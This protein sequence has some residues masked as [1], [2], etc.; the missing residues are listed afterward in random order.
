M[1]RMHVGSFALYT[2][3]MAA[4]AAGCSGAAT[5]G[6]DDAFAPAEASAASPAELARMRAFIESRYPR[7]AV[8]HEFELAS[9][10][11]VDCVDRLEQPSVRGNARALVSIPMAPTHAPIEA[12]GPGKAARGGSEP[13]LS[14]VFMLKGDAD[15]AGRARA[16]PEGSVPMVRL[17][18]DEMSRYPTL[19]AYLH[20]RAA[21]PQAR[22]IG[23]ERH[24]HAQSQLSV[25]NRGSESI[26]NLWNPYVEPDDGFSLSQTWVVRG[27]GADTET[28]ETGLQKWS[29][30][31]DASGQPSFFIYFTP[32]NYGAGGCYNLECS[33][34][35]QTSSS[36][37]IGQH[38]ATTSVSSGAQ[39]EI[40]LMFYKDGENGH[41]WLAYNGN[42]VGYY[43]RDLFDSN[44]LREHGDYLAFGG[45]VAVYPS[46][47]ATHT[48]TDMGSGAF[49]SAGYTRAAYQR[50]MRYIDTS[51][52]Y[53]DPSTIASFASAPGCY[54]VTLGNSP[55]VWGR[56]IFFGGPGQ[57]PT[58]P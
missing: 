12:G 22:T 35:V 17:S 33:G 7:A 1:K 34:F 48:P 8:V 57:S 30:R 51:S 21:L 44:G 54:S 18:L 37:V 45:E 56:Y 41:W 24:E 27:S 13:P 5:G 28:V 46:G 10:Q 23:A 26:L 9:G 3:L 32:D 42:W 58:C 49:A 11:A 55:P 2:G 36:V 6:D 52:F 19:E 25:V 4:I 16:C 38:Y 47:S 50:A 15:H 39:Q 53:A 40:R 29:S 43:P 31:F 20:R 14:D